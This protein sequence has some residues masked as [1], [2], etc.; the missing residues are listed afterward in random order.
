MT[1]PSDPGLEAVVSWLA[2]HTSDPAEFFAHV[3]RKSI[4]EVLDG[5]RT[6]RWD[7]ERL[8]KTEKTYVG[9]KL[10]IVART[11]LELQPAGFMDLE[12]EGY[13]VD[14][15]W[16]KTSAWQIPL[17]A[18]GQ[19]C[20]CVGALKKMTLFQVGVVRCSAEN[21]NLGKNQD[22]KRTLSKMGRQAM[23]VIV[24]PT[25]IPPNFVADM[26]AGIRLKVMSEPT[27]QKRVTKL[28][29]SLP[30][31]PIPR[32]AIRTVAQTEGDPMRRLRKD[33]HA[34]DP[35]GGYDVLSKYDRRLIQ[36]LGYPALEKDEFMSVPIVEIE[37][38]TSA[39]RQAV[40]PPGV[41]NVADAGPDGDP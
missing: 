18:V 8:E 38:L 2:A 20:L 13:P 33:A 37:Q 16:S 22:Q 27:I 12:I 34:G 9:T 3:V 28:F 39:Q 32:N 4:D 35:L 11:A 17:E 23:R 25:P 21:L 5:P 15:K 31:M 41:A 1:G 40:L 10:E 24:P 14:I 30:G 19:L 29:Q 6:G 7:Y 36:A 26:D